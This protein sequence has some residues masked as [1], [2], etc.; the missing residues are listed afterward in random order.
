VPLLD[1][2]EEGNALCG[3]KGWMRVQ[4]ID[5]PRRAL[6]AGRERYR[7]AKSPQSLADLGLDAHAQDIIRRQF[8]AR[9][10]GN[11][12][13]HGHSGGRVAKVDG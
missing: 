9:L 12:G 4:M 6:R 10:C 13:A 1:G 5:N 11:G 7:L 3:P 8:V 2:P